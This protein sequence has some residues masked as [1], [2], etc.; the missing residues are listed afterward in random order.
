MMKEKLQLD[1]EK[2]EAV[3][4]KLEEI[5]KEYKVPVY[6]ENGIVGFDLCN[7]ININVIRRC[8]DYDE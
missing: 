3:L 2:A 1:T 7:L 4:K 8:E 5:G 6:T